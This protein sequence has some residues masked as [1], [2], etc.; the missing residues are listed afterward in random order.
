MV[1][2]KGGKKEYDNLHVIYEKSDNDAQRKHVLHSIGYV[3]DKKLKEAALDWT[4]SGAVKL[5]DF[6][7]PF[8]SG[9]YYL[10]GWMVQWR[11]R[12]ETYWPTG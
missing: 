4:T 6:F 8:N 12:S 9:M 3:A 11:A 5:Q 2:A 1:A 10:F 7:Y